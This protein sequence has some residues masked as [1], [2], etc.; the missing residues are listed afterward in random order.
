MT[1]DTLFTFFYVIFIFLLLI[2]TYN[3][4]FYGV[5]F[6][7]E[8]IYSAV[9]YRFVLGDQRFIDHIPLGQITS[10]ISFPLVKFYY[11]IT[12]SPDGI[13]LFL[14]QAYFI[15]TLLISYLVYL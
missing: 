1:R 12:N 7:D 5:D 15:C 11:A 8:A 10:L 14:R 2:L 9:P 13:I 3:R 6:L 4:L